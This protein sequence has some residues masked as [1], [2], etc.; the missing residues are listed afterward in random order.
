MTQK[1]DYYEVL[2]VA[3]DAD[4]TSIKKAFRKLA[5]QYHPDR[6]SEPGAE[7][8]FKE[9][10]EAY[11]VL[12]DADKRAAYDRFGHEG[13]QGGQP[14]DAS[15][16]FSQFG[17]DLGGIFS[18]LFGGGGRRADPSAPA[19]G[20]DIQ[21]TLQVPFEYAVK[22]GSTPVTIPRQKTCGTCQGSGARPGTSPVTC[23]QCNGRGRIMMQQG[24]FSVQTTC[25]ACNG[26]G[27]VIEH[28]C[29]TCHGRGTERV[30]REINVRIPQGVD[31]GNRLRV[32]GEGNDGR[33]GGPPGDL[34]VALQV[35]M[36]SHYERDGADLHFPCPI[37]FPQ[38][39]LGASIDVPTTDGPRSIT[40]RPG[41]QHGDREVLRG[42]G[43]PRIQGRGRGDLHVHFQIEVPRS[44]TPRQ[45]EALEEFAQTGGQ[46]LNSKQNSVFSSLASFF[47]L[48]PRENGS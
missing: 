11:A 18:E 34:Y 45:K 12:S 46:D 35:E 6:N 1:R 20:T 48:G 43:L 17:G 36:P 38:A 32:P 37:S 9:I 16:I 3:R 25:P 14:F 29:T 23:R 15:D 41:T 10:G 21:I 19:R 4:E 8:K 2:G 26:A 5:N 28:K 24:F 39:A 30:Q 7:E 22:G 47:G 44:L 27:K 33:N 40:I 13:L 42:G 31:T